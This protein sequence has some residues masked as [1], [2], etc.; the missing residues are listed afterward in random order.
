MDCIFCEIINENSPSKLLYE[1]EKIK[2]I[3]D[4]NPNSNGHLL[5][6]PIK[7]Y[8]TFEDLDD[9]ILIEIHNTAKLMN[10]LLTKALNPDGITLVNNYGINQMVKHYHLHIIPV[11]KDDSGLENIDNIFQKIKDVM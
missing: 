2:V 6:I 1:N 11:Y 3:M 7:H 4:I 8:T 9:Q 10:K 5:I